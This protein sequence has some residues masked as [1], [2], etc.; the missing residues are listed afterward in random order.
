[1]VERCLAGLGINDGAK[2]IM[3]LGSVKRQARYT[4]LVR[5]L[6]NKKNKEKL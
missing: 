1:M 5:R 2:E 4:P 6:V 3:F